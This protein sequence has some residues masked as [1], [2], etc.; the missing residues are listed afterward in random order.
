MKVFRVSITLFE[1]LKLGFMFQN[2]VFKPEK[3]DVLCINFMKDTSIR[4][5]LVSDVVY[6][7]FVHFFLINPNLLESITKFFLRPNISVWQRFNFWW[8]LD[9]P[10]P[11][12]S[13]SQELLTVSMKWGF[14]T[15]QLRNLKYL[16][17]FVVAET[18]SIKRGQW[19][20]LVVD[21]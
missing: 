9:I 1:P 19:S 13:F 10:V 18:I 16:L 8:N 4:F 11:C 17:W 14:S 6:F 20:N 7:S 3:L 12:T 21:K 5:T 2:S 15:Q